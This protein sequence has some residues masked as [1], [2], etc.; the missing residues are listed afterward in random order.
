MGAF[1]WISEGSIPANCDL[2]QHGWRLA[3]A[4]EA[5]ADCILIVHA[6]EL[7]VD[8]SRSPQDAWDNAR[9]RTLVS[10]VNAGATRARLLAEGFGEAVSD[11]ATLVEVHARAR[12]LHDLTGWLPRQR[13]IRELE[14]DL[15]AREAAYR[16]RKLGLHPLEF[17]LLWRLSETPGETV[18]KQTLCDEIW[19]VSRGSNGASM[20]VQLSRLRA[21]LGSAG[22]ANLIATIEGGYRFDLAAVHQNQRPVWMATQQVCP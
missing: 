1:R 11:E 18:S 14:L 13:S 20:A 3:E 16:G 8:A 2:R 10:G 4:Q 5:P 17:A 21:K 15:L 12:R 6:A 22:L 19:G 9:R 7:D